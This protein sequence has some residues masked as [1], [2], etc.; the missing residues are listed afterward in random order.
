MKAFDEA[1]FRA[2]PVVAILRG[3]RLEQIRPI[4]EAAKAG[5]L[6]TLEITMNSAQAVEQIRAAAEVAQSAEGPRIN[7]GAGTVVTLDDL[8]AARSAGASFIVTPSFNPRLLSECRSRGVPVFPGAVS[9][10]E[11]LTAWECGATMVKIFPAD[12]LG[13]AHVLRL[14]EILP[15][16]E[17]MPTGGIDL[18]TLGEFHR[19]GAS[20]FG[21]GSPIFDK[22]RVE[23]GDWE[24]LAG[25]CRAFRSAYLEAIGGAP[26][27]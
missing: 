25:R 19:A 4:V 9:P 15:Q 14:K 17:L 3:F 21:V 23:A 24:W 16:L 5:G 22:A 27:P 2:V 26:A 18:R 10:T 13:P 7:V 6:T 11:V 1:I 8:C 12:H 20:A